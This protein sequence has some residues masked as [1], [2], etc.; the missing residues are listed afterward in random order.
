VVSLPIKS[1]M[2]FPP[3]KDAPK[4][5]DDKKKDEKKK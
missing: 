3:K 1:I 4:P 5:K 2:A